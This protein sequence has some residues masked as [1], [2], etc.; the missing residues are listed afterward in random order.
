MGF[1]RDYLTI[2][3]EPRNDIVINDPSVSLH[4]ANLYNPEEGLLIRD[5]CS[6]TGTFIGALKIADY[7]LH[8]GDFIRMG[9]HLMMYTG[10]ENILCHLEGPEF[11]DVVR[12]DEIQITQDFPIGRCDKN[13]IVLDDSNSKASRTHARIIYQQNRFLLEDLGSSNGTRLN[14]KVIDK[15][16]LLRVGDS[17]K[18]FENELIFRRRE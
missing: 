5:R 14:G 10:G 16:E 11:K 2:G 7:K 12:L 6:D 8:D 3:R 1:L 9:D 4:H 17:I 15:I 18:I 13:Y